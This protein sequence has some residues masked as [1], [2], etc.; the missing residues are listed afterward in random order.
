MTLT[1]IINKT[2]NLK[3]FAGLVA[4][5]GFSYGDVLGA[6]EGWAKSILFSPVLRKQ[7]K[8]FF[9]RKDS[10]SLG[11]CNGCQ[12]LSALKELIPGAENWPRFL[13][14]ASEQFE[15][16]LTQVKISDSPS[17]FFKNMAGSILPVP[18]A[19]G[20][21]RAEQNVPADLVA[22]IFVDS[23][24]KTTQRYPYNPNGSPDGI[25][26]LTTPDGRA[27][28]MMPHPERAFLTQQL[29]WHPANWEKESPWFQMFQNAREWVG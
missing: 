20:E 28:I 16:R 25:T 10:F 27:T 23:N 4:C 6:G 14:N 11:V 12:M 21:G 15:A 9:E 18:V 5:G 1:D 13:R 17:I 2:V 24:G 19:H 22:G 29:S 26:A 3:D 7:F 8:E